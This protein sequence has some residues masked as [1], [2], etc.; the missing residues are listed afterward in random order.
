MKESVAIAKEA[1]T[2]KDFSPTRSDN[3]IPRLRDEPE[4]QIGS[5]RDVIGNIRRYGGTPS[6]ESIATELSG[7]PTGERAPALLALQ[8][9]HGNRY[10]QRV[11]AGIQAKLKVGQP[12]DIYE[13]EADRVAD[14]VMRM[15]EPGVQRRAEEED[16]IQI[17][18][19][20]EQITPLVQRQVEE[21]EEEILQTKEAPGQTPDVIPNIESGIQSLR[22][23][24]QPLPES[25]RAFFEPRFGY[26]F[27]G[28]RV[29]SDSRA[30]ESARAVNAMAYTVGHDLVF[31]AGQF[32]PE[33][34][35]GKHL[36]A[37]ELTHVVQQSGT[38][39]WEGARVQRTIGDG[40]DLV[41]PRFAGN[42][43]LEAAF[44]DETLIRKGPGNTVG[45]RGR[46]VELLQQSLLDM[47]Y[48]LPEHGVDS[49]YGPETA[50]AV[51]EFQR[52]AGALL[53]DGIVGPETMGLFDRHDP[54]NLAGQ[55]P[56]ARGGP[57]PSPRPGVGGGLPR[58]TVGNF[59]NSGN[60]SSE[61]NCGFCPLPLGLLAS[62]GNNGMELRG[63]ISGHTSG[64]QYDFKRTKERATWKKVSGTW[65]Q[66]THVGP[67]AD[68]DRSDQDEDLTP[69]NNH[70]YVVDLPGFGSLSNPVG[71]AS[72]T[73]AVYKA[74]FV[75]YVNARIGTGSWSRNSNNF[76]WHS[77]TWLEK[78][79]GT[80]RR[81][82]GKN[83]LATGSTTV[84]T[85]NP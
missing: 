16:L 61:N 34:S 35:E 11:V 71:D 78:V 38:Y 60:T 72:A 45:S 29:H 57:V 82:A 46:H 77:I 62:R 25:V 50:A 76:P 79:G 2:K 44:D 47:G 69:Q 52:D 42:V 81:K 53:I 10:V 63:D 8:Q 39:A 24:G 64:A 85:G 43:E 13:V 70:I 23:G 33:T 31:G 80:W 36:M 75:E 66:L 3:S 41:A 14:A 58:V 9:T 26:D 19:I 84:G 30:A 6:V 20:A 12:G 65:T 73:E 54:T 59:R 32:A 27:S 15:P 40:H 21:E 28:V 48:T 74:S 67:G 68:D 56:P 51:T 49:L 37:H 55:G 22:G 17:E 4:R 1:D 7:M 83:E 5:L 18:P